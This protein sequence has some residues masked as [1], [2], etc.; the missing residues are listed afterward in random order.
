MNVDEVNKSH[1]IYFTNIRQVIAVR[2]WSPRIRPTFIYTIFYPNQARGFEMR[3]GN[4]HEI[5]NMNKCMQIQ[6]LNA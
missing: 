4:G 1:Q 3:K 6:T 2:D 5:I